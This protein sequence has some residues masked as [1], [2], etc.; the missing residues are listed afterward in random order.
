[1]HALYPT[2]HEADISKLID[3]IY[4]MFYPESALKMMRQKCHLSQSELA[5]ISGVKLRS[6]KTYEQGD[7]DICK[8][9]YDTLC[10]LASTLS[11][12]VK[13]LIS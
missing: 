5:R 4:K 11:C 6:I 13:D 3:V 9:Q 2:L 10:A 1:M 12:N 7:L 8:A